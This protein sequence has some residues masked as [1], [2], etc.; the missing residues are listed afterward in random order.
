LTIAAA[1]DGREEIVDAVRALLQEQ[2]A[3]NQSPNGV[4]ELVTPKAIGRFFPEP[5][6]IIRTS[7]EIGFP[8]SC[9]GR[10]H[11][12]SSN[13]TDVYWPPRRR[14]DFL[15]AVRAFQQRQRRFGK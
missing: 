6:L 15:R 14:I 9:Y 13:F 11:L 3:Q 4:M 12:A 2:L 5:D 7:G 8:G 10:A 1:Y